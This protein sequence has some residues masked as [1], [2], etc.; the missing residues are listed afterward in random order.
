MPKESLSII[1]VK[2]LLAVIIF[3]GVGTIIVGGGLLIGKYYK[4]QDNRFIKPAIQEVIITTDKTEYE[5]GEAVKITVENDTDKKVR[6]YTPLLGIE[7]FDNDN[8]VLV[9]MALG[10]CGVT[11][12]LV[13]NTIEPYNTAEYNWQQ[14]EKSCNTLVIVSKPIS[15]QV[16]V[17]EYRVKSV[18]MDLYNADNKQTIYSNEFT[19]KEK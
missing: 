5:Q 15:N 13:Y 19:I 17:G 7:R 3:T 6:I 2:T 1:T 11:G 18:V 10:M 4:N 14:E 9:N 12:G 16:S 8:W